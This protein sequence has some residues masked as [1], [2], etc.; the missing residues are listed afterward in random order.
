MLLVASHLNSRNNAAPSLLYL[1]LCFASVSFAHSWVE[2]I[3]NLDELGNI[4]GVTGYPRGYGKGP[5]RKRVPKILTVTVPR[6]IPV[7]FGFRPKDD[8]NDFSMQN[9]TL[10][11]TAGTGQST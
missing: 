1:F 7:G 11:T 4:T 5:C 10:R 8:F 3:S 2:D 9:L 6:V